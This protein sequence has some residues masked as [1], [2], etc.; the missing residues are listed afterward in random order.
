MAVN[1]GGKLDWTP[2]RDAVKRYGMRNSN[3]LAIAPTATISNIVGVSQ[4][5]E[6]DYRLLYTKSNLSGDFTVVNEHFV[7]RLRD[8]GLWDEQMATDLLFYDGTVQQMERIPADVKQQFKTAFEIEP[9]WLIASAARRQKWIDMGQSLN[10]YLAEPSGRKLNDM[11]IKAWK[12][13]LKTT[14][15]LRSLGASQIEKSTIQEHRVAG[16]SRWRRQAET[17]PSAGTK[18]SGSKAPA[19]GTA[20]RVIGEGAA[21]PAETK[22]AEPVP[23]RLPGDMDGIVCDACQ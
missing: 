17:T 12:S 18:G 23:A 7:R 10:L 9:E 19:N 16:G 3:V 22:G 13:G 20:S 8:E 21:V 4:S 14:Y 6:P 11:Y 2:V 15:Y 1:Q 5:I